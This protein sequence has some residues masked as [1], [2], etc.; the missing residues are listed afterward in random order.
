MKRGDVFPAFVLYAIALTVRLTPLL[1][2]P[3]PYNID[4][5]GQIHLGQLIAATGR[6]SLDQ[7]PINAYHL[8]TPVLPML[9][10]VLAEVLGIDPLV[11]AQF[12]VPALAA[13]VV[14]STYAAAKGMG[15]SRAAAAGA[16]TFLALSGTFVFLT[17]AATKE[18]LGLAL[19]PLLVLLFARR[20]DPRRRALSFLFLALL[21]FLHSL[22]TAMALAFVWLMVLVEPAGVLRSRGFSARRAL[23]DLTSLAGLTALPLTYYS[24]TRLEFFSELFNTEDLVLLLSVAFV[25]AAVAVATSRRKPSM[26]P[27]NSGRGLLLNAKGAVVLAAGLLV[28]A[29]QRRSIFPG[30]ASTSPTLLLVA[31]SYAPLGFLAIV[32][33]ESARA[34]RTKQNGP[35]VALLVAPLGA[36]AFALLR[37]LDPT[38]FILLF[39]TFDYLDFGFAIAIGSAVA[40]RGLWGTLRPKTIGCL[41]LACLLLTLPGAFATEATFRVENSTTPAE[42]AALGHYASL[43]TASGSTDQ[44]YSNTLG[45]YWSVNVQATLPL[46]LAEA[47]SPSGNFLLISEEWAIKGGQ[48]FPLERVMVPEAK[49]AHDM[50]NYNLIYAN[51][52]GLTVLMM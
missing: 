7:D 17:D 4:S 26:V 14:P 12:L 19:L 18:A 16:G 39:R 11:F 36:M 20:E 25:F 21:P 49:L 9:L 31:L 15:A 40:S 30:T 23:L 48:L 13:T 6:F 10:A 28:M 27:P 22:T 51:S 3:L 24:W 42:F 45:L 5:F 41:L 37:G 35:L 33:L 44:R 52:S 43:H 32:G 8:K 1:F 34:S 2:S 29:N 38:S 47:R 50:E 46:D